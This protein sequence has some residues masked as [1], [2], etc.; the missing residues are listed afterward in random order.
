MYQVVDCFL[1]WW[2]YTTHNVVVGMRTE[3]AP[4]IFCGMMIRE[5]I[6]RCGMT[7]IRACLTDGIRM[8][9]KRSGVLDTM[10]V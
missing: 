9:L 10:F 8:C 7:E 2:P 4:G 5:Y 6:G 1:G 3:Y